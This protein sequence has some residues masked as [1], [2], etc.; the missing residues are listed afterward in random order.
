MRISFGKR[1]TFGIYENKQLKNGLLELENRDTMV[2]K[3]KI[4]VSYFS[5]ITIQLKKKACSFKATLNPNSQTIYKQLDIL[6]Y[7]KTPKK[8]T[9]L[10]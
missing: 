2:E 5:Q 7:R 4:L 3:L 9:S 8:H 1:C 6:I 10:K